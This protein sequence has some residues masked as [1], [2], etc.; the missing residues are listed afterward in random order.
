MALSNRDRVGKAFEL[1][2][3][4]LRPFIDQ[5]IGRLAPGADW[6]A[7]LGE[8]KG[9]KVDAEDV[10]AQSL[11]TPF[12]ADARR[13]AQSFVAGEVSAETVARDGFGVQERKTQTNVADIV[14]T[15]DTG[16]TNDP[17]A[18][19]QW[20]FAVGVPVGE[21]LALT[22]LD[23]DVGEPARGEAD[24]AA[25]EARLLELA[26]AVLRRRVGDVVEVHLVVAHAPLDTR[27]AGVRPSLRKQGLTP[28]RPE[29]RF[30]SRISVVC[31]TM[32]RLTV[33]V[34]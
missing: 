27:P 18:S 10:Q 32:R 24:V 34:P 28:Q 21:R 6:A 8:V 16:F 4:G 20:P 11:S 9:K 7:M 15:S 31:R 33:R 23:V 3:D 14:R 2:R 1:L 22:G 17:N 26:E 12:G 25:R 30:P 5:T 19:I 13:G 29:I